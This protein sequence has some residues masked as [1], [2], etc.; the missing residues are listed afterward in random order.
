M[1]TGKFLSSCIF[2]LKHRN[3]RAKKIVN[4]AVVNEDPNARIIRELREE[5]ESLRMKISQ[6][7]KEQTETLELR[8]RLAE[9]E[10]LVA[11]MNK[12]W[13]ERLRETETLN[14]VC[15][16]IR[17]HKT[18]SFTIQERQRDLSEIGISVESSGIKV[19]KDKFYLVNLNA[20]PSLNELLVYYVNGTAIVGNTEEIDASRDSGLGSSVEELHL[21]AS[22]NGDGEKTNIVLRGLGVVHRVFVN[23]RQISERTLLRNGYRLLFGVHHFFKVNCPKEA[24]DGNA[25]EESCMYDYKDAWDEVNGEGAGGISAAVDQLMQ[26]VSIKHEEDKKA[27]LEQQYEAFEQYIQNLQAGGFTPSTPM[28]P[29]WSLATPLGTPASALPPPFPFAGGSGGSSRQTV[30][31]KFFYWAQKKK[32][33]LAESLKRLKVDLIRAHAMTNEANMISKEL[34]VNDKRVTTYDVTLHIPAANLR[35]SKIKAGAFICEPVIVV[36]R[37]GMSG[38]Q[39]WSMS[40]LENKLIDMRELYDDRM[41]EVAEKGMPRGCGSAIERSEQ[42]A[43]EESPSVVIDPFFESQVPIISQQGEVAGRLHVQIYR[44]AGPIESEDDRAV[45]CENLI[46]KVINCRVRIKRVCDL[47]ES[48][49]HFVFCQY[50]FF[51]ATEML[52]VAP[53]HDLS[54]PQPS[55]H[56]VVIF[57]HQRDFPVVVTEEFLEYVQEDALSIEVWGH[58]SCGSEQ[59]DAA[60]KLDA[61]ERNKSLQARWGE[62]SRRLELWMQINELNEN[63]KWEPVE[64]RQFEDVSTGGVYQLRQGQQRRICVGVNL[65][66]SEGLPLHIDSIHSVAIGCIWPRKPSVHKTL[67]SYQAREEDLEVIRSQ[68]TGALQTRQKYLE[69]QLDKL[70]SCSAKSESDKEREHSLMAQWIALTEERAAVAIPAPNSKIP[71]SPCD[72]TPPLGTEKHVPV[73]FL[74]LNPDDMAGEASASEVTLR[75][76]GQHS[77]LPL[78]T[79]GQFIMLPPLQFD[80]KRCCVI[81]PWDS[82]VHDN[83]NLN[84]VTPS[85]ERIYAILKTTVRLSHPC[86]MDVVLR[87]RI[88]MQVYKKSSF[89]ERIFKRMIG[90]ETAY[91]TSVLY[92]LVAHVPKSSCDIEERESLAMLAAK[93]AMGSENEVEAV[94]EQAEGQTNGQTTANPQLSYIEAYTN[95][96]QALAHLSAILTP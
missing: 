80:E 44:V 93:H 84:V 66:F 76:A 48:L 79:N 40:Q 36:R 69:Q 47:P 72:W 65:P 3:F 59:K 1:L 32:E 67:D 73:V 7:K 41:N 54:H 49:S 51:N 82:S 89:A 74:D 50:S 28:T 37:V 83:D 8:E 55:N 57:E 26:R 24:T 16:Y 88:C 14:K 12:S 39:L 61:E 35:P 68:W 95:S 31:S 25:M 17:A 62:V 13:E 94:N 27:A 87:K 9:S 18:I 29:C 5:V 63:G 11:Q 34:A 46:G 75:T 85:N 33:M 70:S 90:T 78:E 20:D 45:G 52:V 23:G 86:A 4:H 19:E 58:R 56:T 60:R 2:C 10:R 53:S 43:D 42:E 91:H 30:K 15:P 77:I 38:A 22:S 64:C 96:I 21:K 71:G 81:C 6:T 92:D